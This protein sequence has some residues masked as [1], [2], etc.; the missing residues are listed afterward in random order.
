MRT[1]DD[2]DGV[3]HVTRSRSQLGPAAAILQMGKRSPEKLSDPGPLCLECVFIH[4]SNVIA[5]VSKD[6]GKDSIRERYE[7][8]SD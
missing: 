6:C 5:P 2:A 8:D 7:N 4:E 1:V 3:T